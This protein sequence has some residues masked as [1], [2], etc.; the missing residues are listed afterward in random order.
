MLSNGVFMADM[1]R[2]AG[3]ALDKGADRLRPH[4]KIRSHLIFFKTLIESPQYIYIYKN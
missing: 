1:E 4:L 2:E 3:V